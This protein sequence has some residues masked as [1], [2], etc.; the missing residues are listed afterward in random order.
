MANTKGS[1]PKAAPKDKLVIDVLPPLHTWEE[2][3]V[4]ESRGHT[5][6]RVGSD[7]DLVLGPTCW[8]MTEELKPYLDA[9]V[10]AARK[11]R[12]A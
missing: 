3:T 12:R 11:A 4:L 8:R 9:A 1:K 5:I 6:R 10:K 2:L 7:A